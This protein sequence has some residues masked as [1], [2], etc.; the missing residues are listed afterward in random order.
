MSCGK[1]LMVRSCDPQQIKIKIIS[2]F[3]DIF[4]TL[5][6]FPVLYIT[7]L[8]SGKSKKDLKFFIYFCFP[9]CSVFVFHDV[10]FV[11]RNLVFACCDVVC[12]FH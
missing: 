7:Y 1:A 6:M 5:H 3:Q 4:H 12:L 9:Q 11:C 2:M 10:V 8:C